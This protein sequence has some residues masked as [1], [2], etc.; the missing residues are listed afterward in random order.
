LAHSFTHWSKV[1]VDHD[2]PNPGRFLV[3][4]RPVKVV[5]I[6]IEDYVWLFRA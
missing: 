5:G 6:L 4:F 2:D 1:I 3:G